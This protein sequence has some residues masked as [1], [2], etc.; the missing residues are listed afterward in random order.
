MIQVEEKGANTPGFE[1]AFPA[2]ES[3]F[4]PDGRRIVLHIEEA[5]DENALREEGH[6]QHVLGGQAH[7]HGSI[8]ILMGRDDNP[9]EELNGFRARGASFTNIFE[10][11]PM[12]RSHKHSH[13]EAILYVIEGS[14]YS[15]IDGKRY[16]WE[17]GD[18]VH[19]PPKMTVHEHINNTRGNVKTLR[20]EFWIRY[21]YEALYPGFKKVEHRLH[22]E[23]LTA[24][25][26]HAYAEEHK[27]THA[28][29]H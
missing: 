9:T 5:G 10:D 25:H 17:A 1:Q 15:E 19:I 27:K 28:H 14:G 3:Q 29:A 13:T 26:E 21:F 20:V 7:R 12:S 22:A 2:Q 4:A 24:E 18:A 6:G 16:D 8:A 23:A 11:V